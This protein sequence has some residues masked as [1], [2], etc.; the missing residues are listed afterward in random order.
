M[1]RR[2]EAWV[3]SCICGLM[4]LGAVSAQDFESAKQNNWH[5][6]RGPNANGTSLTANPPTTW[7]DQTNIKWSIPIVGEGSSTPI[8]WNNQVFVLSAVETDRKPQI[9]PDV[10]PESRTQPT[11]NIFQFVVWSIDRKIIDCRFRDTVKPSIDE[12]LQLFD[13]TTL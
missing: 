7:N 3:G 4:L 10:S 11:G 1:K 9:A 8:V 6:W 2:I 5:Q 13:K 12:G